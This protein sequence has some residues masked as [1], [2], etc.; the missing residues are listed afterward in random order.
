MYSNSAVFLFMTI[1]A[2]GAAVFGSGA[3]P[4]AAWRAWRGEMGGSGGAGSSAAATA[5]PLK[6]RPL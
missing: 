5:S 6:D 3:F 1:L 2:Q 4:F